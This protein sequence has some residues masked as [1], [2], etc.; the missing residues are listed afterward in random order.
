MIR[1]QSFLGVQQK[2]NHR[3]DKPCC[4]DEGLEKENQ[5]GCVGKDRV[6]H[7][8]A[9]VN[10][11]RSQVYEVIILSSISSYQLFFFILYD[12]M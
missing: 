1:R 2:S 3:A 5:I 9:C 11:V 7:F 6:S 10:C 4:H 12:L 8:V